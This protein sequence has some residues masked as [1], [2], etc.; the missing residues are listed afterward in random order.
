MVVPGSCAGFFPRA[1]VTCS[2]RCDQL[3]YQDLVVFCEQ[4]VACHTRRH[5]DYLAVHDAR[6]SLNVF[7]VIVS[8]S[9]LLHP[10]SIHLSHMY[11]PG[12]VPEI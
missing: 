3:V 7:G 6:I 4:L 10:T 2:F 11:E 8:C 5:Y 1:S 12:T 9:Y